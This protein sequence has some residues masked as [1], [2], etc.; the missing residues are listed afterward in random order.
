M[1]ARLGAAMLCA[2]ALGCGGAAQGEVTGTRASEHVAGGEAAEA[3]DRFASRLCDELGRGTEGCAATAQVSAWLPPAACSEA[4]TQVDYAVERIQEQRADCRE[5]SRRVCEEFGSGS[6]ACV[7]VAQDMREIPPGTCG[8]L[9]DRYPELVAQVRKMLD[10]A[11]PLSDDVQATLTAGSPPSLGGAQASVTIVEFSDFQCPYCAMAAATTHSIHEKYGDRVR[12]VF[13]QFPLSFHQDAHLAAQ[14]AL[15]AHAQGKFWELH[16]L[17][18]ENQRALGRAD[19]ERYGKQAGLDMATFTAA[20]D[21]GSMRKT[22]D[23]DL[24]LGEQV[25]VKGTPTMFI[26]GERVENPTDFDALVPTIDALLAQTDTAAAAPANP[27]AGP[28][29]T[30]GQPAAN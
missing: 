22:V 3:C 13:R 20:L 15:A 6:P 21:D 25:R 10:L 1:S 26:N 17:M 12:I 29:K 18:F 24:E 19:L 2:I 7:R 16:D 27:A 23:T 5:F 14:A 9:L 4:L 28:Q 30:P 11:K 8:K